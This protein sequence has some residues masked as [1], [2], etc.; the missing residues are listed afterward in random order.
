[1]KHHIALIL[2][3]ACALPATAQ[4]AYSIYAQQLLDATLARHPEVTVM[5][6]HVTPP[7]GKDNIIVASNIGRIGKKADADDMSV[8]E[9]GTPR[10]ER[11][12]TGDLS[13]ELLLLDTSG[14]TVGVLG[15]TFSARKAADKDSALAL[16]VKLRDELRSQTGSLEA[17]FEPVR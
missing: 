13:V 16:A 12:R 7:H 15:S 6:L 3:G 17:L 9:T 11:T 4:T 5:A 8:L 1:M 2:A 10:I 14:N